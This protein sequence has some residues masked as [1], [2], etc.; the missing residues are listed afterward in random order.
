MSVRCCCKHRAHSHRHLAFPPA[1]THAHMYSPGYP[2][3]SRS[4]ILQPPLR[5]RVQGCACASVLC[6]ICAGGPYAYAGDAAVHFDAPVRLRGVQGTGLRRRVKVPRGKMAL[7]ATRGLSCMCL[8][9][10]RDCASTSCLACAVCRNACTVRSCG[11]STCLCVCVCVCLLCVML[12]GLQF[13]L[14]PYFLTDVLE[15]DWPY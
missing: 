4:S 6:Y 10:V 12:Q 5:A 8:S 15:D 11:I 7:H 1:P 13:R 9:C 14:G 3:C 2:A